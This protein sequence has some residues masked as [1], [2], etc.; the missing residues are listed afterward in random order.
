MIVSL[1]KRSIIHY[2]VATYATVTTAAYEPKGS[3]STLSELPIYRSTP[4]N[5]DPNSH[6]D[7]ILYL[8]DGFG[9]AKHNQRLADKYAQYGKP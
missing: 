8:P 2:E 6:R 7:T 3:F 1:L 5:R 9:L 4:Q